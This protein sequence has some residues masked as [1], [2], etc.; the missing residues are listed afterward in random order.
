MAE[1]TEQNTRKLRRLRRGV[2]VSDV[3]EKTITIENEWSRAHPKYG[4]IIRRRSRLH[5]HDPNNEAKVGDLVEVMACRP[6][7]K[8]KSWRLVRVI[9]R[10]A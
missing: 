2:V 5:V 3:R 8:Q 9:S 10:K 7:S 1:T 4:K 6:V